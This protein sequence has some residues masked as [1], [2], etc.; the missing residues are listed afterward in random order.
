M[1]NTTYIKDGL[2]YFNN[3]KDKRLQIA[4]TYDNKIWG[5]MNPYFE[6]NIEG[7]KR[8][9]ENDYKI[10]NILGYRTAFCFN[11]KYEDTVIDLDSKSVS[12]LDYMT[13]ADDKGYKYINVTTNSMIVYPQQQKYGYII[14]PRDCPVA[15]ITDPNYEFILIIHIGAPQVLT[16]LHN[17]TIKLLD[18]R[19]KDIELKNS[20]VYIT[21]YIHQRNYFIGKE[22]YEMYKSLYGDGF[23]KYVELKYNDVWK[24]DAYYI[25][26]MSIFK[27]QIKDYEIDNIFDCDIDTYESTQH[28]SL[29][30]YKYTQALKKKKEMG[31]NISDEDINRYMGGYNVIVSV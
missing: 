20:N 21:P 28:G 1:D 11:D 18:N 31:E 4:T 23:D 9:E 14:A 29:Y 13:K 24:E 12:Y 10:A 15:I 22:K 25:D 16:G 19:Y 5:N 3:L 27:E 2:L 17:K 8:I 30:S 7:R 6:K 26:Y